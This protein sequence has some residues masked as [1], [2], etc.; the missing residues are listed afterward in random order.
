MTRAVHRDEDLRMTTRRIE[1]HIERLLVRGQRRT[2]AARWRE[3]LEEIVGRQLTTD[4][5]LD[6]STR[7]AFV[8]R[9]RGDAPADARKPGDVGGAIAGAIATHVRA[10]RR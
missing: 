6:A 7:D 2:G 1:L 9:A 5:A 10:F 3:E 8:D 4:R